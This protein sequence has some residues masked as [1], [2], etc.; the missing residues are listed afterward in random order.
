MI[1]TNRGPNESVVEP[2]S[3]RARHSSAEDDP[4]QSTNAN[5]G[6]R[7]TKRAVQRQ[8]WSKKAVR[9]TPT[10]EGRATNVPLESAV[11]GVSSQQPLSE[12][13]SD[14]ELDSTDEENGSDGIGAAQGDDY[15]LLCPYDYL[16]YVLM[17]CSYESPTSTPAEIQNF[18]LS[19][20][21]LSKKNVVYSDENVLCLRIKEKTVRI[22]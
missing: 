3:K 6:D 8:K 7:V 2:P 18:P 21:R 14:E 5:E 10:A 15:R 22:P 9:A 19:K 12:G 4:V 20:V 17:F 16:R 13:E 1:Q 11:Q